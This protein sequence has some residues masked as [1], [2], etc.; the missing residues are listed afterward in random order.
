MT[1]QEFGKKVMVFWGDWKEPE[2]KAAV[3]DWIKSKS[4]T[5]LDVMYRLLTESRPIAYGPLSP[6]DMK[7][8]HAEACDRAELF[9]ADKTN[10][11]QITGPVEEVIHISGYKSE[12]DVCMGP[13]RKK[14]EE[15]QEEAK[16]F[17]ALA[18]KRKE[19]AFPWL[20][21]VSGDEK[22]TLSEDYYTDMSL[23]ERM[24]KY[25]ARRKA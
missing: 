1:P 12:W 4:S 11:L 20:E 2:H 13:I 21:G 3:W 10:K 9:S 6:A 14:Y 15:Q 24:R 25:C 19:P 18:Y 16:E 5:Y 23:D 22:V 17:P 7:E 8:R